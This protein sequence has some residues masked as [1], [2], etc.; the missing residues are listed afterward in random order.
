MRDSSLTL[1]M[2]SARTWLLKHSLMY[3]EKS[4]VKTFFEMTVVL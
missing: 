2:T 1:R 4:H 3:R